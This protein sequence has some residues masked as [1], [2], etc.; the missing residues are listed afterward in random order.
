L[1]LLQTFGR[2]HERQVEIAAHVARLDPHASMKPDE[3]PSAEQTASLKPFIQ[4][5]QALIADLQAARERAEQAELPAED[6]SNGHNLSDALRQARRSV[7]GAL[8][9]LQSGS[10]P[11][12]LQ[13]QQQ[14][15]AAL[16]DVLAG[17][18]NHDWAAKV[19]LGSI[20]IIMLWQSFAPKRLKFLPGPLLAVIIVTAVAWF[21][22]LPVLY[23]EVPDRLV[24]GLTFPLR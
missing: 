8:V 2:L 7:E 9:D 6:D 10:V 15:S 13:S 12:A 4:P 19:G 11:K 3:G 21:A 17:L 24:D 18:K 20:L 16:G 1:D 23:V 5:Q 22:S 14:A